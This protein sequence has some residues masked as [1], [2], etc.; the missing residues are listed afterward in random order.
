MHVQRKA[1]FGCV[2]PLELTSSAF[3]HTV[4]LTTMF[5]FVSYADHI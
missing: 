2:V 3:G 1:I 5:L 4:V